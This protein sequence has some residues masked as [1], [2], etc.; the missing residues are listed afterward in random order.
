MYIRHAGIQK[1]RKTMF[2][3]SDLGVELGLV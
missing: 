1:L 2:R 3:S